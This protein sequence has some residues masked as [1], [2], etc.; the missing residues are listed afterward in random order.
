MPGL[1][2]YFILIIS[3]HLL[4]NQLIFR[5]VD[6]ITPTQVRHIYLMLIFSAAATTISMF[7]HTLKFK[8]YIGPKT[9]YLWY[10]SSY[11]ATFYSWV[12]FSSL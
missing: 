7:L 11:L 3:L 2:F 8:K 4:T 9:S 1:L 12:C 5:F 6:R 10:M